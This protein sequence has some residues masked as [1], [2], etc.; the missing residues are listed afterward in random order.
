[1]ECLEVCRSLHQETPYSLDVN[2]RNQ[3]ITVI[4]LWG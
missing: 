1:M 2:W 4:E 3:A